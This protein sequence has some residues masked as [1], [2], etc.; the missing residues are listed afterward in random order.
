MNNWSIA[1]WFSTDADDGLL[2]TPISFRSVAMSSINEQVNQHEI[3]LNTIVRITHIS[4]MVAD[5][6]VRTKTITYPNGVLHS[7]GNQLENENRNALYFEI[8]SFVE[9]K[10]ALRT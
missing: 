9:S 10:S 3:K 8:E 5:A 1:T 2:N 6:Y 7:N 4:P